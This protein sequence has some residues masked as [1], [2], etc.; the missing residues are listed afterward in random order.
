MFSMGENE[1]PPLLNWPIKRLLSIK[2]ASSSYF[3]LKGLVLNPFSPKGYFYLLAI[4][5][6]NSTYFQSKVLVLHTFSQRNYCKGS[7]ISSRTHFKGWKW[8]FLFLTLQKHAKKQH[9]LPFHPYLALFWKRDEPN[10]AYYSHFSI[11]AF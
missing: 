1:T 6:V 10:Y 4:K 7:S 11:C 9:F 5:T 2:S 3:H 8:D